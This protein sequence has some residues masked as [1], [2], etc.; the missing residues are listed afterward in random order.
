[1]Q[2]N[3]VNSH[4]YTFFRELLHVS[5]HYDIICKIYVNNVKKQ[6]PYVRCFTAKY[7]FYILNQCRQLSRE[8]R[9]CALNYLRQLVVL[10]ALQQCRLQWNRNTTATG[11]MG[12]SK[13]PLSLSHPQS[14]GHHGQPMIP[15][16]WLSNDNNSIRLHTHTYTQQ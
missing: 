1:M 11:V 16:V 10:Q 14:F 8:G 3:R 15:K 5:E 12:T 13:S 4:V 9:Y 2:K 7:I 6:I